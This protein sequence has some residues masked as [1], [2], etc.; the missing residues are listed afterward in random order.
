MRGGPAIDDPMDSA[1]EREHAFLP[2][3]RPT[4]TYSPEYRGE[5]SVRVRAPRRLVPAVG[6]NY[7]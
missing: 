6:N 4:A 5:E 3:I 1:I 2:L 7:I